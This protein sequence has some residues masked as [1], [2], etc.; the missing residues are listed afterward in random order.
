MNILKLKNN[1]NLS[2]TKSNMEPLAYE[3]KHNI[4]TELH[5]FIIGVNTY[6]WQPL[7]P[8]LKV[9]LLLGYM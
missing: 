6:S 5:G 1:F 2:H 9:K 7:G 8:L 3:H 4:I